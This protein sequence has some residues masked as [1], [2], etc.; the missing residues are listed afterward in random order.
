V[1]A[2]RLSAKTDTREWDKVRPFEHF[3]ATSVDEALSL[4]KDYQGEARL[5]AGGTDL[6][7]VLKD[8]IFEE[9]PKALINIKT[10][11][12]VDRIKEEAGGLRL[13]A[14]AKLADIVLSP[15]VQARYPALS[16]AAGSVASPEIR[17][18]ATLGGNLC[19]DVRCW[20]YRYP[21]HMGGRLLC[22]R[23][24]TGACLAIKGDNRYHAI[25]GGKACVAV[26]PS[27]TAVVLAALDARL[28]IVGPEGDW[29]IPIHE[30]FKASGTTLGPSEM[31]TKIELPSAPEGSRQKFLK[32]TLR[33]PVDFALVSVASVIVMENG[34]CRDARIVLGAVAPTPLGA[35]GAEQAVRGK[36]I[37]DA[38]AED[39]ARAAVSGATALSRNAYKV[40][41]TKALVKR[42]IL[43]RT[44]VLEHI[45]LRTFYKAPPSLQSGAMDSCASGS[46]SE[47]QPLPQPWRLFSFYPEPRWQASCPKTPL[48]L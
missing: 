9:Y 26:C 19:R 42:S 13:G 10:I 24:G 28:T 34:F 39:A 7:A 11:P 18:M 36:P 4:M 41:I 5:I 47:L 23:K 45:V 21:H 43:R 27:D 37:D 30:L 46:T 2:H 3:N 25:M 20:Y 1:L 8:Q 15:S 38:T 44:Q 16:Q 35:E 6:L 40:E 17:S 12:G 14:L 48:A 33:E 29:K 32:F 31:L 22:H